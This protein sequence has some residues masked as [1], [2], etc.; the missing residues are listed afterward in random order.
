[1]IS[2]S[3]GTSQLEERHGIDQIR[4]PLMMQKL[5]ETLILRRK[6]IMLA[7]ECNDL[8]L[9]LHPNHPVI[10][11]NRAA[12]LLNLDRNF[13]AFEAAKLALESG[14]QEV[15]AEK[16]SLST[17][18]CGLSSAEL[19]SRGYTLFHFGSIVSNDEKP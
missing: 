15:N 10:L 14:S 9:S 8:A 18:N 17:C 5:K 4:F 16:G 3:R 1:L 19:G 7:Y 2:F 12:V 11:L 13:E 6:S